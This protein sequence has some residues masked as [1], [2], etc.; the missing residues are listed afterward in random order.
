M[1]TVMQYEILV[2]GI[3]TPFQLLKNSQ[4]YVQIFTGQS[5]ARQVRIKCHFSGQFS[6]HTVTLS[7]A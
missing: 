4:P 1:S 6:I 7:T 2:M 3:I 5:K